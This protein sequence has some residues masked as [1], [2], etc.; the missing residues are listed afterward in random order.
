MTSQGRLPLLLSWGVHGQTVALGVRV[1]H[2][3]VTGMLIVPLRFQ[4]DD[5]SAMRSITVDSCHEALGVRWHV[6]SLPAFVYSLAVLL[7]TECVA[8]LYG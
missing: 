7:L 4:K 2:L 3:I 8:T 1:S 6:E 5:L